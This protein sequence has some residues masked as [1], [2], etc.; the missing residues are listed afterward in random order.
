MRE[1]TFKYNGETLVIELLNYVEGGVAVVVKTKGEEPYCTLS[2]NLP[3]KPSKGHFWLKDWSE[4]EPVVKYLLASGFIH[5]TGR[6]CPTGFV[7]AK[8]ARLA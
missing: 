6:T 2:V 5:L 8:E 1:K 4:N 7:E 3:N